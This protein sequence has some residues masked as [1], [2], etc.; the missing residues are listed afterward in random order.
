MLGPV[1]AAAFDRLLEE[2]AAVVTAVGG[3]VQEEAH[4]HA[5]AAA[6]EGRL[7]QVD[8]GLAALRVEGGCRILRLERHEPGLGRHYDDAPPGGWLTS[9]KIDFKRR[10]LVHKIR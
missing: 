4:R 6:A 8:N 9:I 2:Q 1:F 10:R 3:G 7:R 5:L